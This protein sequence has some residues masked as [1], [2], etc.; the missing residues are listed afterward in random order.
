MRYG[1]VQLPT[2]QIWFSQSLKGHRLNKVIV[3]KQHDLATLL[4]MSANTLVWEI[5]VGLQILNMGVG[6]SLYSL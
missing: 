6:M 1:K 4:T 3:K 5:P 2:I